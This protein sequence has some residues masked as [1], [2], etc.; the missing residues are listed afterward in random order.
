[1][2]IIVLETVATVS[3]HKSESQKFKERASNPRTIE[4]LPFKNSIIPGAGPIFQ[5]MISKNDRL[6]GK[7]DQ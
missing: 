5:I 4:L 3:S 2:E 7:A 6:T 1:M